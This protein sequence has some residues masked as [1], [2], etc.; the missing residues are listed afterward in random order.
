MTLDLIAQKPM[1]LLA[2]VD[3]QSKFPKVCYAIIHSKHVKTKVHRSLKSEIKTILVVCHHVLLSLYSYDHSNHHAPISQATDQTLVAAM[4]T[5]HAAHPNYIKP[6]YNLFSSVRSSYMVY[7]ISAAAAATFSDFE[8]SS[9]SIIFTSVCTMMGLSWDFLG[10]ILG[11]SWDY[12]GTIL[13]LS[14]DNMLIDC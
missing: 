10:T 3:E 2:I 4:H 1:N 13:R 7:Y 11:L 6:K 8:H 12:L 9:L 5:K 14:C